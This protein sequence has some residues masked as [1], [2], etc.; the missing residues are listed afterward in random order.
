MAQGGW[1]SQ[2]INILSYFGDIN[3]YKPIVDLTWGWFIIGLIPQTQNSTKTGGPNFGFNSLPIQ[4]KGSSSQLEDKNWDYIGG[5]S[6]DYQLVDFIHPWIKWL[7]LTCGDKL[8][9]GRR[10]HPKWQQVYERILQRWRRF[11]EMKRKDLTSG[12]IGL[13]PT[14]VFWSKKMSSIPSGKLTQLWKQSF[15]STIRLC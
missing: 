10:P 12:R 6:R 9:R 7:S 15:H 8:G 3:R 2:V 5:I 1:R 11:T 4:K 14:L 13:P